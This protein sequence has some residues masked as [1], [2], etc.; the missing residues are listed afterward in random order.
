MQIFGV[1]D[2]FLLK[3]KAST[4]PITALA[5]RIFTKVESSYWDSGTVTIPLLAD[6]TGEVEIVARIDEPV[7]KPL[8][9][10]AASS[11]AIS[12]A[13]GIDF[14]SSQQGKQD[15]QWWRSKGSIGYAPVGKFVSGSDISDL[16]DTTVDIIVATDTKTRGSVHLSSMR[17]SAQDIFAHI[18]EHCRLMPGD[19]LFLGALY[20]VREPLTPKKI[21]VTCDSLSTFSL[22]YVP[23]QDKLKLTLS[24]GSE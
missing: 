10:D 8:S 9:S 18:S 12:Y 4:E 11:L 6:L 19:L 14:G 24:G 22:Q 21:V 16:R 1:R 13:L 17:A 15:G 23:L 7:D 3:D 5:S 20:F 2:N